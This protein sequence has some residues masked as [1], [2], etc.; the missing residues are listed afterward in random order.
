VSLQEI[1]NTQAPEGASAG[2]SPAVAGA[3]ATTVPATEDIRDACRES[4]LTPGEV[5]AAYY[6][7]NGLITAHLDSFVEQRVKATSDF[8]D[9]LTPLL[10]RMQSTLSKQGKLRKLLD[11]AGAP[12]WGEWFE[13]F[14]K[15]LHLDIT[16]RTIQRWLKQYRETENPPAPDVN[17]TAKESIRHLESKPQAEKLDTAVHS[18][19]ELNPAIRAELIRVLEARA[20]KYLALAAKLKKGFKPCIARQTTSG[21]RSRSY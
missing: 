21:T 18:R 11:L 19:K 4:D 16:F 2:T 5:R 8:K 1:Q 17:V 6:E 14:E 3:E 15:R 12:Q 9:L 7:L 20:K 13:D 10:D